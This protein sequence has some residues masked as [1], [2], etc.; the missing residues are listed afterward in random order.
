MC[1]CQQHSNSS[2]ET[3][4]VEPQSG[5]NFRVDDMTCGHCAGTIKKAI[6]TTLPGTTVNA[7]PASKLVTVQGFGD[8]AAIKSIVIGAGYKPSAAPASA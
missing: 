1:S 5:L 7:D 2:A 3:T 8:Y 4:T 6:E